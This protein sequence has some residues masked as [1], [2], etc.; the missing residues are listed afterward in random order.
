MTETKRTA[1]RNGFEITE[2]KNCEILKGAVHRVPSP[3]TR[4]QRISLRLSAFLLDKI[5]QAGL[6]TVLGPQCSVMLTPGDI[7]RPDIFFIRESRKGIIGERMVQGPPDLA[8]EIVSDRIRTRHLKAKRRVYADTGVRECWIVDPASETVEP[9]VWSELGY[10]SAG[11]Y[12]KR[13]RLSS[14]MFP[15]LGLPVSRIFAR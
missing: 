3:T 10:I 9:Q 7:V 12:G 14:P 1:L 2:E 15:E 5:E 4:H 8:V 6:G 13:R 11:V